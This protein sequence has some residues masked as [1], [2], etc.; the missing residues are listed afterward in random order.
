MLGDRRR[1]RADGSLANRPFTRKTSNKIALARK[2]HADQRMTVQEICASRP[3]WEMYAVSDL[4]DEVSVLSTT[5]PPTCSG[6]TLP[7]TTEKHAGSSALT[8]VEDADG[9]DGTS[10]AAQPSSLMR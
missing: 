4:R 5:R 6:G 9:R 2:L 7:L 10:P 1:E 8:S 3:D